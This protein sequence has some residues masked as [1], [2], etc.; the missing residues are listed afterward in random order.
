M[1]EKDSIK[2]VI[3]QDFSV[4]IGQSLAQAMASAMAGLPADVTPRVVVDSPLAAWSLR[5]ALAQTGWPGRAQG[6][7]LPWCGTLEQAFD[8]VVTTVVTQALQQ[9]RPMGEITLP[10][11]VALRRVQL[12]QSLLDF[13]GIAQSLGG[14]SK[15][16]LDLAGQWVDLFE[17]WE[18]CSQRPDYL[19]AEW[20]ASH[21][22]SDLA[23]L[24]ELQ[25]ANAQPNDRVAWMVRHAPQAADAS[26]GVTVVWFCLARQPSPQERA[27]AEVLEE[28]P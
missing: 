27:M 22:Q 14:S 5:S 15:A 23:T 28:M 25:A 2:P 21:L 18:W 6:K 3:P 12:A 7:P 24:R 8:D 26:A 17:G 19:T 11:S 20:P 4:P 1:S 9:G 10:R 13:K 16:A